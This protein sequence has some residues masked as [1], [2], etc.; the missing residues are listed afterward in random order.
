MYKFISALFI[1]ALVATAAVQAAPQL[2]NSCTQ[3]SD[4]A[5][6]IFC[7]ATTPALFAANLA[8]YFALIKSSEM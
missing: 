7:V 1:S 2:G 3:N 4:A 8:H 6:A 5:L